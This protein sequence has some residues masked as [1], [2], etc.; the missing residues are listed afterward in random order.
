MV[1]TP[2]RASRLDWLNYH[3]L[4]YFWMISQE[5]GLAKAAA[6]LRLSHSTLSTQ[7]KAL[8]DFLG[9][10]LFERRGRRL[11]LTPLGAEIAEQAK[12]REAAEAGKRERL[13]A[14]ELGLDIYDMRPRLEALGLRYV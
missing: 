5:G 2:E 14:G 3:H 11:T 13:A 9:N 8:E 4:F 12:A 10:P 6:R 7:L 1:T